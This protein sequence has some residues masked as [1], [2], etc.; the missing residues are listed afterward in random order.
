MPDNTPGMDGV[1]KGDLLLL[2]PNALWLL[3]QLLDAIEQGKPWPVVTNNARTAYVSKGEDD[4]C[5]TGCRGLAILSKLYRLWATIRLEHA[6]QWVAR[7][8]TDDLFAGTCQ[9][10]GAED[11]WYR[12][13]LLLEEARIYGI[14]L[15]G[16]LL[17]CGSVLTKSR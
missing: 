17:M 4:L 7:W 10:V 12:M 15:T 8:A 9:T 16:A 6:Q 2:S 13:G 14:P 5:P 1:R 3:T 11:A